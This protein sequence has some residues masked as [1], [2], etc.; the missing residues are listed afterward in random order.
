MIKNNLKKFTAIAIVFTMTFS[1]V[2]CEKDKNSKSA[3]VQHE[4]VSTQLDATEETEINLT[5]QAENDISI[6]E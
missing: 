6:K 5:E 2:G 1:M 4:S 3:I